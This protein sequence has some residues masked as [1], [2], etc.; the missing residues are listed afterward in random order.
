M[1]TARNSLCPSGSTRELRNVLDGCARFDQAGAT[2]S[3][4]RRPGKEVALAGV[5]EQRDPI[6]AAVAV[7]QQVGGQLALAGQGASVDGV[8]LDLTALADDSRDLSMALRLAL[9]RALDV[10]AS[11]FALLVLSPLLLVIAAL[12]KLTDGGPVFFSQPRVG[13]GR[14]T[15]A[16][17]K[18]RSMVVD[19]DRLRPRL[20]VH[21]ESNGPVFKMRLDPRVTA[22]GRFIRR[23]S[24]DE[25][26]Q[27]INV[28]LGEMSLV[29]PR[30]SLP[31]EVANYEPWQY[32]RFAVRPG[33]TCLWQVSP[34]RYRISF[35]EWMRL[36]LK[37]IDSWSLRLDL[38]LIL[39]TFSVVVGGTGQ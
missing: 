4:D 17:L 15:F 14:Q 12:I 23:Y 37:Y 18:F 16:M 22:V 19:A 29:G 7:C 9:K 33:L 2:P 20:E 25:L 11:A 8:P 24:L 30:P 5:A 27:L 39:R 34:R 1:L 10:A 35:D 3:A 38:G 32:R 6:E 36:D 31:S 21:N 26:P 28:L 13:F